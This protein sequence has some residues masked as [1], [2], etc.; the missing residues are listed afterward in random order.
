MGP[1]YAAPPTYAAAPSVMPTSSPFVMAPGATYA[2]G[3]VPMSSS[4]IPTSYATAPLP[5]TTSIPAPVVSSEP[6]AVIQP[7]VSAPVQE[8]AP[9]MVEDP[10]MVY[11]AGV[12]APSAAA[13]EV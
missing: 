1:T 11:P 9:P 2:T 6:V 5:V 8:F 13:S 3:P 12:P 7:A 4:T 10:Q